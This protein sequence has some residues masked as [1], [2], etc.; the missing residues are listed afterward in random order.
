[1]HPKD[2]TGLRAILKKYFLF[3][4]DENSRTLFLGYSVAAERLKAQ[5][6]EAG[7]VISKETPLYV[8]LPCGVGGGPGGVAFGLKMIFEDNVHC[9]FCRA[10][11][12]L[13]YDAWD[14]H[15]YA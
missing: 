4:D 10:N 14:D 13:L 15:G 1:M 3:I 5:F 7:I 9:F 2:W 6:D 12:I 8:Y 11:R